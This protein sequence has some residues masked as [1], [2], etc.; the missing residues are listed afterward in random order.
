MRLFVAID[1]P[2][3]VKESIWNVS[4]RLKRIKG[5]KVVEREN[6]HIT[7]K[8]LG[9]VKESSIKE[10]SERLSGINSEPFSVSVE[11]IGSF[12]SK[13]RPRVI[14]VGINRGYD[15]ILL[16]KKKIDVS[17][18]PMFGSEKRFSPH[19][20]IARAKYP[21]KWSLIDDVISGFREQI[22]GGF[23]VLGFSLK[24]SILKPEGPLYSDIL[25]VRF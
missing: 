9:E 18:S 8:F 19:I 25:N 17:L 24:K 23:E 22:F 11:G 10:I 15:E 21:L 6:L 14:W 1:L 16:L 7:L 12:P 13:K 5:L 20:T 4:E 2:E 3:E